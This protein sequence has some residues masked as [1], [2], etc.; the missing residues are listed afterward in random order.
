MEQGIQA[1]LEAAKEKS[2]RFVESME[3]HVTP[4]DYDTM[5]DKRFAGSVWLP[6]VAR[7]RMKLCVVGDAVHYTETERAQVAGKTVEVLKRFNET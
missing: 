2:R 4:N 3:L 1:I 7:P 6:Y 5:R